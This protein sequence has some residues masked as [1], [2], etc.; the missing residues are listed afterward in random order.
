MDFW[1]QEDF[2]LQY[3]QIDVLNFYAWFYFRGYQNMGFFVIEL[4]F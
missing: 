2:W 3:S 1:G 4:I